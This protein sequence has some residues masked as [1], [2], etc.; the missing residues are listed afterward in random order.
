MRPPRHGYA[1]PGR[2]PAPTRRRRVR[3]AGTRDSPSR[4]DALAARRRCLAAGPS[5]RDGAGWLSTAARQDRQGETDIAGIR[6]IYARGTTATSHKRPR[7][8]IR[9]RSVPIGVV[10]LAT[11]YNRARA[12]FEV[13]LC[14]NA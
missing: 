9:P 8:S 5:R 6:A 14:P 12:H 11:H 3:R 10:R 13:D 2:E 7:V 1:T 4:P